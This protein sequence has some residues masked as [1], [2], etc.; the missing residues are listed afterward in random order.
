MQPREIDEHIRAGRHS[1]IGLHS[2]L[3]CSVCRSRGGLSKNI[4]LYPIK[5][6]DR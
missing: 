6:D 3:Y 1:L 2:K 5:R 4:S